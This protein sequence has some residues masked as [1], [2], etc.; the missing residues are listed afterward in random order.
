MQCRLLFAI[1]LSLAATTMGQE[2]VRLDAD[3][4]PLPPGV[5]LRLGTKVWRV[6]GYAMSPSWS[7]DG[8][9]LA[10]VTNNRDVVIFDA[11]TGQPQVTFQPKDAAGAA[12]TPCMGVAFAPDGDE[13]AI[14]STGRLVTYEAGTGKFLQNY[15]VKVEDLGGT[16]GTVRYSPDGKYLAGTFYISYAVID[17]KSGEVVV[18]ER[19][20]NQVR[21]LA[22]TADSKR[23]VVGSYSP[24]LKI[25]DLEKREVVSKSNQERH[26][27]TTVG[28]AVSPD[29]NLVAQGGREVVIYDLAADRVKTRLPAEDATDPFIEV[30]YLPEGKMLAAA[31]Q[32]GSLYLWNTADWSRKAKLTH[33]GS[34]CRG[35]AISADG[36][37]AAVTDQRSRIWVWDLE[38]GRLVGDDRPA[39]DAAVGATAFSPDGTTLAT[40]S[41]GKDTHLWDAKS[42]RHLRKLETSS[43][44]L[45]FADGGRKLI[46]TWTLAPHLRTWDLATGQEAGQW[47]ADDAVQFSVPSADLSYVVVVSSKQVEPR[48][49][50][51][52]RLTYPD[53]KPA[54]QVEREG[55]TRTVGVSRDGRLA[56]VWGQYGID[57]W[58]LADGKLISELKGQGYSESAHFTPDGRYLVGTL[59]DRSIKVWEL[60]SLEAVHTLAGDKWMPM[61]LAVSPNGR[62]AASG[63]ASVGLPAGG[64]EPRRIRFWDLASGQEIASLVG[65]DADVSSLAFSADG[66]RL[67]SGLRDTTVLVWDVPEAARNPTFASQELA[68]DELDAL[69]SQLGSADAKAARAAIVRLAGDPRQ[70]VAAAERHLTPAAPLDEPSLAALIQELDAEEFADRRAALDKLASLGSVIEPKLKAT[71]A[72]TESGEIRLRCGELLNLMQRRYPLAGPALAQSRAVQLLEWIGDERAKAL[73]TKLAA[74][75]AEGHLTKEAK[76]AVERLGR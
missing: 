10:V 27:E 25:W 73:L 11:R 37:R 29:A 12:I 3:G 8:K 56:A 47:T 21:G 72:T 67:A 59:Q 16:A 64:D 18:Q 43:Q 70:A 14:R 20:D 65:H 74:G 71:I 60:A 9:R 62:V 69:W 32:Q 5:V 54:G 38:R 53:L 33:D 23:L 19:I 68:D 17:R 42:G 34:Y 50:R 76:L 28:L 40:G 57:L 15:E 1:A 30:A 63:S 51:V 7:A 48:G 31:T 6:G 45:A 13:L 22:F 75:S 61:A 36:K 26:G 55:Y 52:Q 41:D 66:T 35:M 24:P 44:R 58:N 46:T 4:D 49:Y 39:H 2:P